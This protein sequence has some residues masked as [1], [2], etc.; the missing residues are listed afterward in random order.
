MKKKALVTGGCG[1]IGSNLTVKLVKMGWDV[2]VVDDL[3]SG[4]LGTLDGID[5]RVVTPELSL[6]YEDSGIIED[7]TLVITGDF[8][9]PY[10]LSRVADKKYDY[11][12]HLA[13]LPRVQ[14][15]VENPALTTDQ[16]VM[17]TVSLMTACA[18]NIKRFI[19]SSSSAIYGNVPDNFPSK[20]SGSYEPS[21][22]YALQK[23]VVENFC[24]LFFKLYNLESVCLRYFN[25]FGP[26]QP[27]DSPY[28]T[29]VSA[30]LD[31]ISSGQPLRSDGD[32]EQTRDIVYIDDIVDANIAAADTTSTMKGNVYNV[33]TG[34]A[35]SNNEVLGLLKNKF[36]NLEI[37]HAPERPGDVKHTKADVSKIAKELNFQPKWDFISGLNETIKW[38]ELEE[39]S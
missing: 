25:V 17:K 29:A 18:K 32:G 8:A 1:F 20:E 24:D 19:F 2:D 7:K 4:D 16:N 36:G 6:Q 11:V 33:G 12:F 3:S 14:F 30:W 35:Y 10:I 31:K 37:T 26:G 39:N 13:A 34:A 22:P 27:G 28:S 15:S 23:L 21:S 9:S 38:W 5:I